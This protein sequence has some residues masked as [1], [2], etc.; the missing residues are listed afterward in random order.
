MSA[1]EIYF[2]P[3]GNH[4]VFEHFDTETV[5]INLK[6]GFYFSLNPAGQRIWDLL[7]RMPTLDEVVYAI[8]PGDH[9]DGKAIHAEV[10]AFLEKLTE[11]GLVKMTADRPENTGLPNQKSPIAYETPQIQVFTDQQEL[12]L[13]DPIHEVDEPGWPTPSQD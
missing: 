10:A 8:S 11:H 5:M 9:G 13:L 1:K 12:L 6:S 4:V 2:K 3:E 7:L